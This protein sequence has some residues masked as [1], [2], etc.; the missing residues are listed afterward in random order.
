MQEEEERRE[1]ERGTEIDLGLEI[2]ILNQRRGCRSAFSQFNRQ[3]AP[4]LTEPMS[5]TEGE[6][7]SCCRGKT[8]PNRKFSHLSF[9]QKQDLLPGKVL[10]ASHPGLAPPGMAT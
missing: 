8:K 1:G 9:P 4:A 7:I 2:N 5:L 3:K 6:I 10:H